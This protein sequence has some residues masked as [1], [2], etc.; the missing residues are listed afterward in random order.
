MSDNTNK[1][2]TIR[3]NRLLWRIP[4]VVHF[5]SHT[6]DGDLCDG[7]ETTIEYQVWGC[8]GTTL[9]TGFRA[10]ADA[11]AYR[12]SIMATKKPNSHKQD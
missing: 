7:C 10:R 2:N 12:D 1:T 5:C 4:R 9:K 3:C 8:D 11:V 6:E